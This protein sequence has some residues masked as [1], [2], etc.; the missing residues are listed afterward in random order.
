MGFSRHGL[1]CPPPGDLPN[2]GLNGVSYT[3]G[4]FFIIWTT[5]E[6][7]RCICRYSVPQSVS[8][9]LRP[10]GLQYD[11]LLC[12]SL[13]PGVCSNSRQLSLWCHPTISSSVTLFSSCLQ[14][15]PASGSSPVSW[16]FASGGQSIRAS[17]SASVLPMN[18]KGWFP[19]GL[20]SL[21]YLLP[22]T[23]RHSQ[24][25]SPAPQFKIIN[26]MAFSLLY[27]PAL[28]FIWLLEKPYLWLW[29]PLLAKWCLCF[30]ICY[31]SFL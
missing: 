8:D 5:R 23:P 29:R 2:R 28:T 20:T 22:K 1:P 21:F 19:L 14:P 15:F 31:L 13:S 16:L 27:G 7:Q 18:I 24:E 17:A 11:R 3:A 30:L 4:R 25:S 12:P 6:P 10:H 9:C 26:S